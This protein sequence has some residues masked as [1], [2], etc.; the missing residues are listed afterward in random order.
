[1]FNEE[2]KQRFLVY[3]CANRSGDL[4]ARATMNAVSPMEEYAGVDIAQMNN[5]EAS[6]AVSELDISSLAT[7]YS[8]RVVIRD[9]LDWCRDNHVF[10]DVSDEFLT[11]L[12]SK[13]IDI[14]PGIARMLFRDEDDLILSMR[15]VYP[16]GNGYFEPVV[17]ALA[18]LGLK[19]QDALYLRD[20]DVDLRERRIYDCDGNV[21]ASDFSDGVHEILYD[22]AETRVGLRDNRTGTYQVVKDYSYDRFIKRFAVFESEKIGK[23]LTIAHL[24]SAVNK[25]NQR[26]VSLGYPPRLTFSNVWKSGRCHA[27]WVLESSGVDVFSQD[28]ADLVTGIFKQSNRVNI[29]WFYKAY[30]KAFN[31]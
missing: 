19:K 17:L 4:E 15:K 28:N 14:S 24:E 31:L 27:L 18:W 26:Y 10:E 2:I 11:V 23:P 9:Y 6:A 3:Y 7:L 20:D 16:L 30:K 13:K 29:L 5:K 8:R 1:M 21:I 12:S 22:F 25:M